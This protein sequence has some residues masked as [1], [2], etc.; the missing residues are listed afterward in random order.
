MKKILIVPNPERDPDLI[1]T[2]ETVNCL[3]NME[4][5]AVEEVADSIGSGV[6]PLPHSQLYQSIDLVIALGG[7]GTLLSSARDA[8]VYNV[9]VLGINLGHLGFLS[10]IEKQDIKESLARLEQGQF[11]I[12]NRM[13]L[14]AS[15]SHPGGEIVTF[16]ALNDIVVSR[17]ESSRLINVNVCVDGQF[18][19]DYKADG[20]IIATPTGSTAYSMSAGG[21]IL[22]PIL[23]SFVIT[24]ICPHKLY[25]KSIVVPDSRKITM[26]ISNQN[27]RPAMVNSDGLGDAVFSQGDVLTISR[28]DYTARLIK[29][30]GDR[31]YSVLRNKLLGKES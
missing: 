31:F 26:T 29:I 7:D 5:Y 4:L 14:K 23:E 10:E 8:A 9:P 24:P 17:C 28:S 25:T 30:N 3:N 2:K 6:I 1:Y 12:E 27:P 11:T 13:M 20:M 19:D 15:L 18:V 22:D 21:P 16:H